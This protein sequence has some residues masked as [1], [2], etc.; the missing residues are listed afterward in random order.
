MCDFQKHDHFM[1][2]TYAAIYMA[3]ELQRAIPIFLTHSYMH[4]L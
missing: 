1:A 4:T 3:G 2:G